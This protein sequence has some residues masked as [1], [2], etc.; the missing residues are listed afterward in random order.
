[1]FLMKWKIKLNL[2]LQNN[3]I[4]EALKLEIYYSSYLYKNR[5]S[6]F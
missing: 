6:N 5:L 1:M 2:V 4:L 3:F